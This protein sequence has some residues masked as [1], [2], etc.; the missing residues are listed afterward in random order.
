MHITVIKAYSKKASES[1]N[2]KD[3]IYSFL[4]K[5]LVKLYSLLDRKYYEITS[6][7]SLKTMV[8]FLFL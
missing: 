7:F 2:S 5:Y 8:S 6:I 4:L 3:Y 1:K